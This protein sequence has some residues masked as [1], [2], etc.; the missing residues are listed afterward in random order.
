[1]MRLKTLLWV[2]PF[3]L[4]PISSATLA[5]YA[6]GSVLVVYTDLVGIGSTATSWGTVVLS[7]AMPYTGMPSCASGWASPVFTF[8]MDT[9]AGRAMFQQITLAQVLH[10]P[11][12]VNGTGD[13]SNAWGGRETAFQV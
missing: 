11:V 5:G 13:C 10:S 3:L 6:A 12:T 2:C 4:L 8:S 9:P 7:G 1:M